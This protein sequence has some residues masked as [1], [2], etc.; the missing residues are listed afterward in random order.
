MDAV[1]FLKEKE[2]MCK[3]YNC[4]CE[5]CPF[6]ES[7]QGIHH[8]LCAFKVDMWEPEEYVECVEEWAK[9]H[10]VMTN[11]KIFEEIFGYDPRPA[12]FDPAFVKMW[13][14]PYRGS[15]KIVKDKNR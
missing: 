7:D 3:S 1:E 14:E 11:A 4:I 8:V 5:A 6:R 15:A 12:T 10:P 13:D 2:R 9:E